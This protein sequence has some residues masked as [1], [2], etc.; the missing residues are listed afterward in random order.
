MAVDIYPKV[1]VATQ[2]FISIDAISTGY[3][4]S[5]ITV[6]SSPISISDYKTKTVQGW[7]NFNGTLT[8]YTSYSPG[9]FHP[10]PYYS[11]TINSGTTFTASFSEAFAEVKVSIKNTS[12]TGLAFVGVTATSL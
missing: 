6:T 7:A 10:Y 2:N 11:T 9:L 1:T 4:G 8:I 3:V 5:G 12:S